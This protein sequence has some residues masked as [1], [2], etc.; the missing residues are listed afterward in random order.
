MT[1]Y[2][3]FEDRKP[4]SSNTMGRGEAAAVAAACGCFCI[5]LF[6]L[7][8]FLVFNFRA[9]HSRP[10]M[11]LLQIAALAVLFGLGISSV[12]LSQGFRPTAR[13]WATWALFAFGI[14]SFTVTAK[15]GPSEEK[16]LASQW[17]LAP[18]AIMLLLRAVTIPPSAAPHSASISW[19]RAPYMLE[20]PLGGVFLVLLFRQL[21]S[22][23][24]VGLYP[25]SW[26]VVASPW[27]LL[28][29][30]TVSTGFRAIVSTSSSTLPP[31]GTADRVEWV[32]HHEW[33]ALGVGSGSLAGGLL[34]IAVLCT[35]ATTLNGTGGKD[36]GGGDGASA[37]GFAPMSILIALPFSCCVCC[38]LCLAD[39]PPR[40]LL[41]RAGRGRK[42]AHGASSGSEGSSPLLSGGGEAT[43]PSPHLL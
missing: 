7:T 2:K 18:F 37:M 34:R 14:L 36:D 5:G 20:L 35:F 19:S 32:R 13:T 22:G 24:G 12:V 16:M 1:S 38:C 23:A 9:I 33:H 10:F 17:A 25:T 11:S 21:E 15:Y 4:K 29:I 42:V 28:E 43:V 6:S 41:T 40:S 31:A 26:W 30:L 3:T 39:A 8:L 27:L